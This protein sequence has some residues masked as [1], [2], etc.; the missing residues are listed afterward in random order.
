MLTL[1]VLPHATT[2]QLVHLH[3][4]KD[5]L[6]AHLA[7]LATTALKGLSCVHHAQL[8]QL[9]RTLELLIYHSVLIALLVHF[10]MLDLLLALIVRPA[11]LQI[12]QDYQIA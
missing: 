1:R 3:N 6:V 5:H 8:E 11:H 10:L 2:A 4:I 7:L 9:I 12:S